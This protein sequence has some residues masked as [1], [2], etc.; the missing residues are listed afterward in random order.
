MK[1][2][3]GRV[4]F[5]I[6]VIVLGLVLYNAS[7]F[8]PTPQGTLK[9]IAHRG[10][11]QQFAHGA[12]KDD[13]CTARM[14]EPPT[15]DRLENTARS[16]EDAI[17]QGA[18]MVQVD[19]VVTRDGKVALFHDWTLDCRTEATGPTR[20][21]TLAELQALDAGFGYTA[22]GGKSYPFRGAR[23]YPIPSLEEALRA[24]RGKPLL[25]NFKSKDPVEAEV[26]AEALKE[27]DRRVETIGDGFN[28]VAAQRAVIRTHFPKAWVF[29]K[30]S[31]MACT[32]GY[33]VKGWLGQ[34]PE[35]CRNGTMMVPINYQWAFPGWPNRTLA[36]MKA[37]GARVIMIG[38]K[39]EGG[40][41][42]L[43][44]PE[45]LG[46]VPNSFKGHVWVSD[47]WNVGP[48]LRPNRDLRTNEQLKAARAALEARRTARE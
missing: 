13:D 4:A 31:V 25:F 35:A 45:Q 17:N 18:D 19:V 47:I 27:A 43:D 30:D 10:V 5:V 39:G 23:K 8:A 33:A 21:K 14:I 7:F 1:R 37:V 48:A 20:Y 15:H 3:V 32:K 2:W 24:S 36:R 26:L 16:I 9:L 28:G 29:G 11:S 41:M 12:I 38:P 6:A 22:D 44:L 40:A 46:E 34:V 42:G